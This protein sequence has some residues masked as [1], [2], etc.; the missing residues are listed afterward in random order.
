[1]ATSLRPPKLGSV[2]QFPLSKISASPDLAEVTVGLKFVG[3]ES[4]DQFRNQLQANQLA[5]AKRMADLRK[6]YTIDTAPELWKLATP[7]ATKAQLD[8]IREVFAEI[9][10]DVRAPGEV[11]EGEDAQAV[12]NGLGLAEKGRLFGV[13]LEAQGANRRQIFRPEDPRVVSAEASPDPAQ[14]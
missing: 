7:E 3:S 14:S 2:E 4:A 12:V 13:C 6:G 9:V 1:M 5:E 11:I 8:L 10:A